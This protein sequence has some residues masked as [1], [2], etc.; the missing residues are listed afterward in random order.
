MKEIN[1][2]SHNLSHD[3]LSKLS[4]LKIRLKDKKILI[5]GIKEKIYL[6]IKAVFGKAITKPK[7]IEPKL[8]NFTAVV[9]VFVDLIIDVKNTH[10]EKIATVNKPILINNK[11]VRFFTAKYMNKPY[12]IIEN[13]NTE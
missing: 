11:I 1:V 4:K 13:E 2:F 10:A 12:D 3:I 9:P 7:R 8:K 6:V 5:C